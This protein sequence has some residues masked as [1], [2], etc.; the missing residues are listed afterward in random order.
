MAGFL[1]VCL[2]YT[3]PS[4][5]GR[6]YTLYILG[7]IP[8]IYGYNS[9]SSARRKL[10]AQSMPVSIFTMGTGKGVSDITAQRFPLEMAK[11]G[12][13]GFMVQY[14]R[15]DFLNYCDGDFDRK[16]D[17]IYGTGSG[18]A[19]GVIEAQLPF[20]SSQRGLAASGF[21]QG[22]HIALLAR[23]YN[24]LISSILCHSK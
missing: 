8:D 11:R 3:T 1:R 20:C 15:S 6:T 7:Y 12:Y 19:L 5:N 2:P 16:G 21:S 17:F 18:S 24:T 22:G 13:C 23:Q 14:P 10:R 9:V 4:F